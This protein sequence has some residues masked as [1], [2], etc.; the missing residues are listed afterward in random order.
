MHSNKIIT[1]FLSEKIFTGNSKTKHNN[2]SSYFALQ[3]FYDSNFFLARLFLI[4]M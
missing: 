4:K 2:M 1:T 3:T